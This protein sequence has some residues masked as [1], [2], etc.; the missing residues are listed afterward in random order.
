MGGIFAG[1]SGKMNFTKRKRQN[2]VYIVFFVFLAEKA[3]DQEDSNVVL[4]VCHAVFWILLVFNGVSTVIYTLRLFRGDTFRTLYRPLVG[5]RYNGVFRW[6]YI[7]NSDLNASSRQCY[8]YLKIIEFQLC[9]QILVI[10]RSS[11]VL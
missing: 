8:N 7:Y 9:K 1:N 3:F 4:R 5:T 10:Q 11:V 6:S 2:K